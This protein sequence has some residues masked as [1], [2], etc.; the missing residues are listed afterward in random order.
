MNVY[1]ITYKTYRF[2]TVTRLAMIVAKDRGDALEYLKEE[3]V[4][5]NDPDAYVVEVE[6][7][8]LDKPGCL[9]ISTKIG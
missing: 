3:A 6:E 1:K 5:S 7:V 4:Y 9:L 8:N 2:G